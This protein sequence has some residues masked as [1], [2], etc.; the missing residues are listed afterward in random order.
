MTCP[1]YKKPE[2]QSRLGSC[3]SKKYKARITNQAYEKILCLS[4]TSFR[5]CAHFYENSDKE[6]K[7]SSFICVIKECLGIFKKSSK[8]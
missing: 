3:N 7:I 5:Q 1:F 6:A 8:V 2:E 4:K